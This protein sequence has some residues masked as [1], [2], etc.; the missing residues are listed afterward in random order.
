MLNNLINSR[1]LPDF[2]GKLT[3]QQTSSSLKRLFTNCRFH[4][5]IA[6]RLSKIYIVSCAVCPQV[7]PPRRFQSNEVQLFCECS[8]FINTQNIRVTAVCVR[9]LYCIVLTCVNFVC[10]Q[11]LRRLKFQVLR[12]RYLSEVNTHRLQVA[13]CSASRRYAHSH[14]WQLNSAILRGILRKYLLNA[15]YCA[16]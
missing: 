16:L 1:K 3:E 12:D 5:R 13:N 4:E 2:D 10:V 14:I 7:C 9:C 8:C 6:A 11:R 15:V